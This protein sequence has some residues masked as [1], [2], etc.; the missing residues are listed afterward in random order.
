MLRLLVPTMAQ[1]LL[2]LALVP[3]TAL[4]QTGRSTPVTVS[5]PI[6]TYV[7][8]GQTLGVSCSMRVTDDVFQTLGL[9]GYYVDTAP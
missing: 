2:L 9:T 7:D 4:G 8:A 6:T 5:L 3:L 1:G